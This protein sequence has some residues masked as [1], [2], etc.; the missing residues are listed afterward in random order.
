VSAI[1]AVPA[2]IVGFLFLISAK[3][4]AIA[5]LEQGGIEEQ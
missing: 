1:F 5:L 4:G 3:D 2:F